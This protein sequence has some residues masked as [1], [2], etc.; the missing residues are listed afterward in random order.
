M[1]VMHV[2]MYVCICVYMYNM[3]YTYTYHILVIN[4]DQSGCSSVEHL[5]KSPVVIATYVFYVWVM[6]S[7]QQTTFQ[8]FADNY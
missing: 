6:L 1:C 5:R 8:K 3:L 7:F 2:C 4:I